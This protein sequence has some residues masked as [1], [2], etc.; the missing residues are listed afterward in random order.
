VVSGIVGQRIAQI[1]PDT[2][3]FGANFGKGGTHLP[4]PGIAVIFNDK[5]A[6]R[7]T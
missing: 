1:G 5:D 7:Y 3:D 2:I 6:H 4:K